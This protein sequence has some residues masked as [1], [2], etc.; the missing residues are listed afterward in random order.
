MKTTHILDP[1]IEGRKNFKK[2]LEKDDIFGFCS[3]ETYDSAK[4]GALAAKRAW[5]RFRGAVNLFFNFR[6][7]L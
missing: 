7:R 4:T 2:I 5:V 3:Y 1:L 6:I